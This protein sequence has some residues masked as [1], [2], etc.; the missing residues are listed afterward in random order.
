M[1]SG[2][3]AKTAEGTVRRTETGEVVWTLL[4]EGVT[5]DQDMVVGTYVE[6]DP[7]AMQSLKETF[8]AQHPELGIFFPAAT[9]AHQARCVNP[10]YD[11][12]GACYSCGRTVVRGVASYL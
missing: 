2:E 3:A 10:D 8:A 5:E 9:P 4:W 12:N 11:A 7:A 1:F 6:S